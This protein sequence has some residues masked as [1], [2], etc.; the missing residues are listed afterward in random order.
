MGTTYCGVEDVAPLSKV[1]HRLDVMMAGRWLLGGHCVNL[2]RE[3]LEL[4]LKRHRNTI[5]KRL[6]IPGE[7]IAR[8]DLQLLPTHLVH[9]RLYTLPRI[10][11]IRDKEGYSGLIRYV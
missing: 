4:D 11:G 7:S 1:M 5:F 2:S 8:L 10:A 6:A 9:G 3:L